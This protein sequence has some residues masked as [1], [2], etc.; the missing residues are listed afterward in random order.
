MKAVLQLFVA[1][2]LL[3][4]GALAVAM[5]IHIASDEHEQATMP[6]HEMA[7]EAKSSMP[8]CQDMNDATCHAICSVAALPINH[9]IASQPPLTSPV[10]VVTRDGVLAAHRDTPLRPPILIS[11]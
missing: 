9:L 8:C 2:T 3:L 11:V 5:P 4:Q 7:D 1:M 6:C 10:E